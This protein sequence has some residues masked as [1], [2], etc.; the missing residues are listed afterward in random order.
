[1][2]TFHDLPAA[3]DPEDGT[4]DEPDPSF[5]RAGQRS[6][7]LET[8]LRTTPREHHVISGDRPTGDLHLGHLLGTLA[9]RVRLQRMGVPLTLVIADYQVIADRDSPGP[10]TAR[11]RSLVADYLAAGVDPEGATIFPHSAVPALNQLLLPFLS[12]VSDAELRRNPTVKAESEA[13][14]RPLSG[15]LLTYPVHQAADILFCGGTVVPVGRDQ[16]PHLELTRLIARR[17]NDRYGPVFDIPE[18]MLSTVPVLLGIDGNK[19]SKSRGNAIA[20]GDDEDTTARLIRRARTDSLRHIAFDPLRRPEV[21]SLL[22]MAAALTGRSPVD[23][24]A[25]IGNGGAGALKAAV[26]EAV[27]ET[28]RP[29]RSRRRELMADPGFLDGVLLDGIAE[30]NSMASQKLH[31]VRAAMG[32]DY[33]R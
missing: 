12:L 31:R 4:A 27:N 5:A 33:L 8:E 2:T 11:V 23:V 20:L 28:L 13:A 32:M 30:A 7:E 15:L 29:L 21:A 1:M 17:F 25:G 16:L 26:I 3:L 24:A 14:A 10:L 19:M 9:N 18:A 6:V 22:Q